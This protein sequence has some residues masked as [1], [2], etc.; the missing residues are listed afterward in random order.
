MPLDEAD[1]VV[2]TGSTAV[3]YESDSHPWIAEQEELVD[4][5]I[6]ALVAE[7]EI[8]IRSALH[9]RTTADIEI[10]GPQFRRYRRESSIG[11]I[12]GLYPLC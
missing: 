10:Q 8:V 2:L 3:I 1:D 12:E 9:G 11:G 5:G 4:R 7:I 6:P